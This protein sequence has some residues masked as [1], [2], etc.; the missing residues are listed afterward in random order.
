M[1]GEC[2][3]DWREGCDHNRGMSGVKTMGEGGREGG[4]EGGGRC[5]YLHWVEDGLQH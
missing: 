5:F 3:R 1:E 2:D 4:R